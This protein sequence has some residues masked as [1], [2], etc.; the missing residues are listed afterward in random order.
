M[1]VLEARRRG[2]AKKYT[3]KKY[4]VV[5]AYTAK[6]YNKQGFMQGNM[7][8]A[9]YSNYVPGG[10]GAQFSFPYAEDYENWADKYSSYP[11]VAIVRYDDYYAEYPKTSD[12]VYYA[13]SADRSGFYYHTVYK[14][15]LTDQRSSYI[16]DVTS[17]DENAYPAN[18]VQGG[19]W[20]VKQ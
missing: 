9:A 15:E 5:Q 7:L 11:Y 18:G 13:Y 14:R 16:E 19:Y 17:T 4:K 12:T 2:A 10:S 8:G 20:Y 1:S 6:A 3:W